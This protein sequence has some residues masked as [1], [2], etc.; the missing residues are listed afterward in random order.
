MTPSAPRWH[1]SGGPMP[2]RFSPFGTDL[3]GEPAKQDTERG[4]LADAYIMPPLSVLRTDS[5]RWQERKRA[6]LSHGIRS[7]IGRGDNLAYNHGGEF[8][9]TTRQ[10]ANADD[11]AAGTSI[12]DPVL[13]ELAYA[14]WCPPGGRV[15]DPFAGGSVRGIVAALMGY[16]YFGI[17]LRA[18]QVAANREQAATITPDNPPRWVCGDSANVKAEAAGVFDFV[19][20]CPPYGDLERYSDDPRDLSTMDYATFR[21]SLGAILADC[22]DLLA[23]DAFAVVVVGDIRDERGN[24][25]GF[26]ADVVRMAT[27]C[28]LGYYNHATLV[29]VIGSKSVTAAANFRFR[30]L[31]KQHQDVLVFIKGDAREVVRRMNEGEA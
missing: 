4:T 11:G 17:E 27:D 28:G 1:V 16:D 19:F 7:E 15:L 29:N 5:G 10:G 21:Q 8:R 31:S 20:T 26:P 18:E 13:C 14:W 24:Y 6:W 2:T 25:R 12:F 30:K 22:F 9:E 3:F 23:A